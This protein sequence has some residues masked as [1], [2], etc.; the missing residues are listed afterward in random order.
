MGRDVAIKVLHAKYSTDPAAVARFIAEARAVAKIS[1]PGIVEVHEFGELPD[2]RHYCVMELVRGQ[3]L[4]D[5]LRERGRLPIDEALP[6]LRAIAE[7][8]D[9]AHAAGIA[10]RDLKPDN[11]FVLPDGGIKVIDFG[12][13][14]LTSDA[15]APVT[16]TGSMFGTPLYMSPEQCR[17]KAT[18]TRT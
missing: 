8:I 4:R 3:T 10:H 14:K 5:V 16:E 18:D 6:V 13:A 11:V 7:A 12:L 2:G 9:A 17:G 15:S 1:H